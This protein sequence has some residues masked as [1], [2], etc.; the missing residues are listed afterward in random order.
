MHPFG[1]G[2]LVACLVTSGLD[3]A[4]GDSRPFGDGTH[5]GGARRRRCGRRRDLGAAA[6]R[7]R[8]PLQLVAFREAFRRRGAVLRGWR[9]PCRLE[10]AMPEGPRVV[11]IGGLGRSGSTILDLMLGQLPGFVAV[12]ELAY[13]WG[14]SDADLWVRPGVLPVPVLDRGGRTRLRRVVP[15][16]PPPDRRVA[17]R[18]RTQPSDPGTRSGRPRG[19]RAARAGRGDPPAPSGHRFGEW[20]GRRDRLDRS[21]RPAPITSTRWAPTCG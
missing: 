12:G 16:G 3:R 9:Q 17:R 1:R 14:R 11:F 20:R 5:P 10:R 18:D 2:W 19:R 6:W 7:F 13:V 4:R 15:S 8:A 21:I